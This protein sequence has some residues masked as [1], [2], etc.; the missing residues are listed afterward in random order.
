ME[1]ESP[2]TA[3]T[4]DLFT[5]LGE[6]RLTG[7]QIR[8]ELVLHP[9]GVAD[10]L[11]A[12]VAM[13]FL[14]REGDGAD[15][16]Y[17]NTPATALYLDRQSPRYIGG[18]LEMLNARL[19]KYWHDLPEALRTGQPQNEIKH[20]E[21]GIFDELYADPTKLE[22]FLDAMTGLSRINFE[23]LADKFDFSRYRTLCDVG[24]ATGLLS[25]EVAK[26]HPHMK[27]ISFDLPP[28]EPVAR[29][30]ITAAGLTD[31]IRI[32]SGNFFRDPLPKADVITMGMI[33]HD[34][35]LE[36]KMQLIR[37]AYD[38]LSPGGAFIVVEA[39]IDNARRENVF[40]L[41]MSLNMLI[42][43]GDAFDY[44]AADFEKWCREVGFKRFEVIHLAGPSSAAIAY[45]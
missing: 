29:K 15:A 2:V 20:G 13:K 8:G 22:Q 24:G 9:R 36:K 28:V 37:A 10:F 25:I 21:K 39:L 26:K 45:K 38:A 18:I 11:D 42:E 32:A 5:K 30:Y 4:I 1:F 7:A 23:A 41:L 34:W 19:F 3:V 35:N 6:R 17:F 43:F 12:L 16:K 33:L 14:E 31:R 44:S 40:G 27:F